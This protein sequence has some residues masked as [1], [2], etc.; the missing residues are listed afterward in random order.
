QPPNRSLLRQLHEASGGNPLHALEI[1]RA[2][3]RQGWRV[4]PG[5]ALPVP[6]DLRG[7]LGERVGALPAHVREALLVASVSSD[8]APAL[9][10]A[11]TGAGSELDAAVEAGVIAVD[12]ERIRF[13]HPLFA[14]A[15]RRQAG[16]VRLRQVR[17]RLAEHAPSGEERALHLA[18]GSSA[19]DE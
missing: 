13:V 1:G 6:E 9:L 16:A 15:I 11:V 5:G 2:L 17:R 12:S 10:E 4:D 7:L 3:E 8:P 18:L 19:P 14:S